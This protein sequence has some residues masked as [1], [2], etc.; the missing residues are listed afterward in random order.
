MN[1]NNSMT[2]NLSARSRGTPLPDNDRAR[3]R[4]IIERTDSYRAAALLGVGEPTLASALAGLGL[5]RCSV[6]AI[7][8]SLDALDAKQEHAREQ[9][10]GEAE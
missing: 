2:R 8:L 4:T 6:T 3:L 9:N 1:D 5:R 7:V 10:F